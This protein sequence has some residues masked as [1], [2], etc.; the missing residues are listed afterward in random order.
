[1]NSL[2]TALITG[3]AKRIGR[4]MALNL[5]SKGYDIIIT[6]NNS[7]QDAKDLATEIK[8]NFSRNCEIV[9]CNL[10]KIDETK[11]LAKS[12]KTNFPNWNLLINNA[13]IFNKS[14]FL[15]HDE[16]ELEENLNIHFISP[17]ILAKSFA[18]NCV[19]GSQIINFLD[20]N[21]VRQKTSYFY[22]LLSKKNLA[23]LTKMLAVELAPEIRVNAVA[24]GFILNSINETNPEL[25]SEI[26]LK[27]IPLKSQGD[28][29]N[30]WQAIEFFLDN[31]YI[32]GQIIFVDGGTYLN[33]NIYTYNNDS[34]LSS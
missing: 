23:T 26:L 2:G 7:L 21:I 31:S 10:T 6:Y 20:K 16:N 14:N 34:N 19:K 33:H 30:I 11:A 24:P 18:T 29:K 12:I 13:S 5:A 32:N 8:N 28:V 25:E 3:G 15:D 4:H 1:M 27:T 17:L 22:Y 9:K